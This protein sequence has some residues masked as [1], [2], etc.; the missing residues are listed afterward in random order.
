MMSFRNFYIIFYIN[1]YNK[2]SIIFL[3]IC[4]LLPKVGSCKCRFLRWF[5]NTN[6]SQCELFIYGGCHGNKNQFQTLNECNDICGELYI[7]KDIYLYMYI[8]ISSELCFQYF[9]HRLL[10]WSSKQDVQ[11]RYL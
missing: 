1:K 4:D 9:A 11:F 3:G 6:S 5:F 8:I 10:I 2:Q 7:Y